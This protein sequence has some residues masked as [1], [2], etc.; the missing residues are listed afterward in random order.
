MML[1][2][3]SKRLFKKEDTNT[4]IKDTNHFIPLLNYIIIAFE[5]IEFVIAA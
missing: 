2:I 5:L 3:I 1:K 4:N